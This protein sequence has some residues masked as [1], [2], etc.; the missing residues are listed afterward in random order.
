MRRGAGSCNRL[1]TLDPEPVL[2]PIDFTAVLA[3]FLGMMVV[4]IP[5]TGLTARFALKPVVESFAKIFQSKG[6]E[7]SLAITDR[8][9]ALLEQQLEV[10]DETVRRLTDAHDFDAQLKAGRSKAL[11]A[12]E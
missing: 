8:R 4:L 7:E 2:Q 3:I 11:P 5:I 9:V 10:M 6:V 12:S 1:P